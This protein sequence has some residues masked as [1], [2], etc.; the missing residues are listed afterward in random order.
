MLVVFIVLAMTLSCSQETDVFDEV[1]LA[2]VENEDTNVEENTDDG[3]TS[4]EEEDSNQEDDQT[5]DSSDTTNDGQQ[6]S[7][8]IIWNTNFETVQWSSKGSAANGMWETEGDTQVRRVDDAR[9]SK[10]A[11]WLG[12]FN[13]GSTR[14]EIKANRLLDWGEHW[15]GFSMKVTEALPSARTYIQF[16][17]T[18]K[19]GGVGKG[20]INPVTLRQ[21]N[22]PGQMYF[23]T[24]TN[25]SNVD[26]IYETGAST[27]T[28]STVFDYELDE[29][30]DF[31]IHWVLDPEDGYLEIWVNGEKIVDERGTTTYRYAHVDGEPYDGDV[32]VQM[33]LYWG[34]NNSPQGNAFY[35]EFKVWKGAGGTYEDVSPGG[36]SPK[37]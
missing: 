15:I 23:Q 19:S 25:E 37:N 7:S 9:F 17:N 20:V 32:G 16:R 4:S 5:D 14:N 18:R 27:G 1:V 35:D 30:I 34:K 28:Q 10:Q 6:D 22:R 31:V 24:S 8:S 26:K 2:D 11:I 29:Y 36:L 33:G 12:D 3:D 21:R 13:N